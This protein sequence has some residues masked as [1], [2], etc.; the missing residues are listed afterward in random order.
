MQVFKYYSGLRARRFTPNVTYSGNIERVCQI[1]LSSNGI[2]S[3]YGLFESTCPSNSVHSA[4][5][6]Y[7]Q[8]LTIV[9]PST[10]IPKSNKLHKARYFHMS[11]QGI[12]SVLNLDLSGQGQEARRP[13]TLHV[14]APF[15]E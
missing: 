8:S 15:G 12:L 11:L 6:K 10:V 5:K 4:Y 9:T 2:V 3:Y 13:F 1:P 14:D 7:D